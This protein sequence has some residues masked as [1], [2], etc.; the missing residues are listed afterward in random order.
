[1]EKV[2]AQFCQLVTDFCLSALVF[3]LKVKYVLELER[4]VKLNKFEE[5][6]TQRCSLNRSAWHS[7]NFD[8]HILPFSDKTLP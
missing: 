5:L 4:L 7:E 3:L 2:E 1:M 6:V 8:E